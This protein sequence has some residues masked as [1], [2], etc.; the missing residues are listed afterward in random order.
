MLRGLLVRP[1]CKPNPHQTGTVGQGGRVVRPVSYSRHNATRTSIHE[2]PVTD[3]Q[4][5]RLHD[6]VTGEVGV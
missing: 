5:I 4:E 1:K 3:T 6:R 2:K